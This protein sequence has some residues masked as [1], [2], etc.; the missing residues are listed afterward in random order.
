MAKTVSW[1]WL[2]DLQGHK[3]GA[4]KP[5]HGSA[6]ATRNG[7]FG[8]Y[9]P[10]VASILQRGTILYPVTTGSTAGLLAGLA[11]TTALEITCPNLN[12]CHIHVGHLGVTVLRA[13]PPE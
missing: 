5:I 8:G 11:G 12:V 3:S 13:I 2:N 4:H 10:L 6:V 1:E 9:T 7:R